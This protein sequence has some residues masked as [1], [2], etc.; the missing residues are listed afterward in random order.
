M[1]WRYPLY[2]IKDS[3][4]VDIDPINEN[5]LCF[6]SEIAGY[7]NEHNFDS[8]DPSN[9][10]PRSR[11]KTNAAFIL[12]HSFLD[13]RSSSALIGEGPLYYSFGIGTLDDE[14]VKI[15]PVDGW[16]SFA[17]KN[18]NPTSDGVRLEF[19]AKGG[20]TWL[21]ASFQVW[22]CPAAR[23]DA[24]K[25]FGF[26]FALRLDGTILPD[27]ILGSGDTGQEWMKQGGTVPISIPPTRGDS[28]TIDLY[29][30]DDAVV[31]EPLGG[32]GVSAARLPIVL[33]AVVNLPAGN[34]VLEVAVMNIRASMVSDPTP[35]EF[36]STG[37]VDRYAYIIDRDMFAMEMLS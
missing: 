26:L 15:Q 34:H 35:A 18:A 4:V 14:W 17:E 32:G 9:R 30:V 27:T 23:I 21:S 12:H 10:I 20:T 11:F 3:Y 24:Q 7:L 33:D 16:Q 5:F 6:T 25:G 2:A 36:S 29:E 22:C 19:V 13:R 31:N 8:D 28:D 37:V 1:A